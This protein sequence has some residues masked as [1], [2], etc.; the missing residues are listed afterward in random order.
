MADTVQDLGT[1]A[2][3]LAKRAHAAAA[4]LRAVSTE[5]K[6]AALRAIAARL[7]AER[8]AIREANRRDLE[9]ADQF[10]LTRAQ[11][12]RL[13]LTDD[14]IEAMAQGVEAIADLPDPVGEVID[15]YIRADG[16]QIR[17]VRVPLGVVLFIYESR[18]N[19]TVDAVAL[20]LKS[21]NAVILRGGKEAAHTNEILHRLMA[22]EIARAGLPRDTAVRVDIQD[23]ALVGH[24]LQCDRYIDLAIPRGGEG[25][26]RRVAAEARMPVLKH[27]KGLCHIYVDR[28]A[29]L[30]MARRIVVNAKCQRPGV[31]NAVETVLV[32]E[33]IAD[34]LLPGLLQELFERGVEVRGCERTR[35]ADPRV[36]PASDDDYAT[37]WLDLKLSLRVVPS[38]EEAVAHIARFG[39]GHT[40]A[41]VT[42]DEKAADRFLTLVDSATVMHNASTRLCD[43]GEFGLGAEIGLS[44]D[45]LH[46]RGPCGLRELTTYKYV[47]RGS[48]HIR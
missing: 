44:T 5:Q 42:E 18:P 31:C 7:R 10:G 43:G 32:H 30:D 27:Y 16:L 22:D 33:A 13:T 39:S 1:Y 4:A 14:R 28:A 35:Q 19:V 3:M 9:Q 29:N 48:G 17:R 11:I 25:L 46:A 2:E 6:D 26:I 38:L 34:E 41:I 36:R 20:C 40:E 12:D 47:V 45:K 21:G 15:E 8:E 24:L 23:R 37:E